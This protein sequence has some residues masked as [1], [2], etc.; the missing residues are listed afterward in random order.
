MGGNNGPPIYTLLNFPAG[1]SLAA[2]GT[3]PGAASPVSPEPWSGARWPLFVHWK[4]AIVCTE[5]TGQ[6]ARDSS[7]L[8]A[9][10]EG[11]PWGVSSS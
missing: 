9:I 1:P 5:D 10:R 7:A 4:L 3:S 8:V 11:D 6:T 2:P